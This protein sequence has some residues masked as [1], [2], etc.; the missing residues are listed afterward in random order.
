MNQY[1]EH[2]LRLHQQFPVADAHRDLAPEIYWR[3]QAGE[4]HII[5]THF[6]PAM[7]RSG[8]SLIVSSLF[9]EQEFLPGRGMDMTFRQIEALRED[10]A[11]SG[12]QLMTIETRHDLEYSLDHHIPGI[13]LYCEGLDQIEGNLSA[14]D[15]LFS[16]GVRG[17]SLTWSR[18][19][20]LATGTCRPDR[21]E[22]IRGGIT[23]AGHAILTHM[24][25]LS[26]FVDVSHLNDDGFDD[27]LALQKRTVIA[28]H[29]NCRSICRSYRNLTDEQIRKLAAQGGVTGLNN[30]LF[31]T[32]ENLTTQEQKIAALADHLEHIIAVAGDDHAG[33]GFDLCNSY[34][35][36]YAAANPG[37]EPFLADS[38]TGDYDDIPLIT[39]EMLRRGHSDTTLEKIMG[40]NFITLFKKLLP[41]G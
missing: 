40:R 14:L 18:K 37:T 4:Q 26:M 17:A 19:N 38:L 34:S 20:T 32:G 5:E 35:R 2:A 15:T 29:S 10:I 6:L 25:E 22:D 31:F 30:G 27:M 11:S 13:L 9:I 41:D 28:T 7:R 1:T 23:A 33:F 21:Y 3:T 24:N 12:G 39:A 16:M 36:S 8:V